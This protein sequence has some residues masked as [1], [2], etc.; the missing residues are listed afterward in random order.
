MNQNNMKYIRLSLLIMP[1]ILVTALESFGQVAPPDTLRHDIVARALTRQDDVILR[2]VPT[3]PMAW[4]TGMLGGYRI[5]RAVM[6]NNTPGS[7]T[8]LATIKPWEADVWVQRTDTTQKHLMMAAEIMFG[9]PPQPTQ[10]TELTPAE[11]QIDIERRHMFAGMVADFDSTAA[12][13][14]GLRY[15]DYNVD[16]TQDYLYRL[17]VEDLQ[18]AY[19]AIAVPVDT[20]SVLVRFGIDQSLMM[21]PG[22]LIDEGD[23]QLTL[24]WDPDVQLFPY[25]AFDIERSEDGGATYVQMNELPLVFSDDTL[26]VPVERVFADTTVINYQTYRYRVYGRTPFG[27]R[28][29]PAEAEGMPRDLVPPV[30]PIITDGIPLQGTSVQLNWDL[31]GPPDSDLDGFIV[32]HGTGEEGP[33]EM[34]LENVLPPEARTTIV[35]NA[36]GD[37]LNYYLVAARDTA[38]NYAY[39]L[40]RYVHLIDTIPPA[41][42]VNITA[43]V[44]TSGHLTLLWDRGP[45]VDLYGYRIFKA[46]QADHDFSL[47]TGDPVLDTTYVDTVQ[48]VTLTRALYYEIT[49]L[50]YNYNPSDPSRIRVELPDVVPPEAPVITVVTPTDSAVT[51]QW[52]PSSSADVVQHTVL[53]MEKGQN[54]WA[55]IITLGSNAQIYTDRSVIRK[56]VY[57]YAVEAQDS[58]GFVSISD[59]VQAMSYD[60]GI[61]PGVEQLT[62][63]VDSESGA[64]RLSWQ[65]PNPD[66]GEYWFVVY[67]GLDGGPLQEYRSANNALTFDDTQPSNRSE[68]TYQYAIHVLY[69]DGRMSRLSAPVEIAYP[70]EQ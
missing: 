48:V 38:G 37:S 4:V 2:W 50:D 33:F 5:D 14:L 30:A 40:P 41:P 19:Q 63:T 17:T 21:P 1:V 10:G 53:R 46:N 57:I 55:E 3:S 23:R 65:Y 44:D 24:S 45:E 15:V 51:L 68:S 36:R 35:D 29:T 39:S 47:I 59:P 56:Q 43:R 32:G 8:T 9:P 70:R 6:N 52:A 64:V 28:S 18:P 31:E 27:E 13:A 12:E 62:A 22:L 58:T 7:W 54:Q 26:D 11:R 60:S 49:A 25:I 34:D 16:V 61:R 42:P 67:R 69:A 66:T 20:G